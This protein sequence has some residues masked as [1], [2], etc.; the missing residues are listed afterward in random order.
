MILADLLLYEITKEKSYY[1]DA[2]EAAKAAY[3]TFLRQEEKSG[4]CYY[5]DFVWFV[6]I[7]T[8]AYASLAEYDKENV[9]LYLEVLAQSIDFANKAFSAG[10]GLL[11]HDYIKGWRNDDNYDRMLLTHSGT[12]EIALLL[13]V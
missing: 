2:T 11:P 12:A 5:D 7:L 4:L 6:A 9:R 1:T 3:T 8:E 13:T 10:T